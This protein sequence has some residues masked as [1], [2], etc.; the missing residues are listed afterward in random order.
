M[1]PGAGAPKRLTGADIDGSVCGWSRDGKWIYLA[2]PINGLIGA[3]RIWKVSPEGAAPVP[4]TPGPGDG[5]AIE[6]ADGRFLFYLQDT[7][8]TATLWRMRL[9]AGKPEKVLDA[10]FGLNFA[11]TDAVCS[12]SRA[13]TRLRSSF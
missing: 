13:Q 2:R 6:S 12:S 4:V 7:S 5:P 1:R 3:N 8:P 11:V 10:V 9:P